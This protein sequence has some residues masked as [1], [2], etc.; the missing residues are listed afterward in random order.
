VKLLAKVLL[1]IAA[2]QYGI[3]PLIADFSETHVFHP[4]WPPHARFHLVWLLALGSAL[5]AYVVFSVWVPAAN[6]PGLL[7]QVSL[8]G[9]FVLG[10]FFVAAAALDMYGGSFTDE[11]EPNMILGVTANVFSFTIAAILQ[12]TA[13]FLLWFRIEE[14]E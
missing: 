6:R 11:T 8:M 9:C 3:M 10:A 4:D 13:T 12:L 14:G 2:V 1:T 5:A 7:K